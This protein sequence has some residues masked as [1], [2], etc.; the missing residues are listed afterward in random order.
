MP[1]ASL[2]LLGLGLL[3]LA[4]QTLTELSLAGPRLFGLGSSKRACSMVEAAG[5]Q[6]KI[7][8]KQF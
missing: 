7:R 4:E 8:G 5:P 3:S 2:A 1:R 6:C